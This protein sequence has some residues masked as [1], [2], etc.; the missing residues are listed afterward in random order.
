M[1]DA[2][3]RPGSAAYR[4]A[5]RRLL[6]Q[7]N[8]GLARLD[9]ALGPQRDR[10]RALVPYGDELEPDD[11]KQIPE[12][13]MPPGTPPWMRSLKQWATRKGT[14]PEAKRATSE[15]RVPTG[16]RPWE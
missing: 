6:E 5:M 16:E 14:T 2:T 1:P 12:H 10:N 13:D 15:V 11:R 9:G 7:W 4:A 8:A 3:A